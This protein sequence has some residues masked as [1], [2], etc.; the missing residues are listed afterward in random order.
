[1]ASDAVNALRQA[2]LE[3][4]DLHEQLIDVPEWGIKLKMKTMT[5]DD[6][7]AFSEAM[8]QYGLEDEMPPHM[9]AQL[10]I[11]CA[12]HHETDELVFTHDDA[13]WLGNKNGAVLERLA[14]IAADVSGMGPDA[15]AAMGKGSS[16][17]GSVVSSS[18]SAS[19]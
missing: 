1:M 16:S 15:E 18:D 5:G 14:K 2:I 11:A 7:Q 13:N 9:L 6:R 19:S 17:A 10:V 4:Q 8:S 3:A 12:R